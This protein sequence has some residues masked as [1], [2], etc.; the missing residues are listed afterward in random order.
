MDRRWFV[1]GLLAGLIAPFGAATAT[2][3]LQPA[4]LTAP[5]SADLDR[6]AAYLDGIGTMYARFRQVASDGTVASGQ[7]WVERPGRMRFEYD[8]PS[9]IL[10]LADGWYVHYVDKSLAEETKVG[11]KSTPAWFLLRE[12]IA[13]DS[14]L[15]VTRFERGAQ[16]LRVTVV[17]KDQAD[18]GTLTMVFRRQPLA[19]RQWTIVDQ[20]GTS[21]TVTLSG[22]RV[23]MPLDA[24]L[25]TYQNPYAETNQDKGN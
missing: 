23:G 22:V 24:K 2:P 16:A 25:F 8:P 17:Q 19:L 20:R 3:A 1:V 12:R 4:A 6:V 9:P 5:D 13:F 15:V 10:L 18:N 7:M 14:D 21:T 11:L